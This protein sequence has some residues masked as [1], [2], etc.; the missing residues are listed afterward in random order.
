MARALFGSDVF[1]IFPYQL[2]GYGNPE[3]LESGAWWFYRKLGFVPRA[4]RAVALMKEEER[5]MA[6][7]PT[8]RTS[9]ADLRVLASENLYWFGGRARNDA[10]GLVELPNVGLRVTDAVAARFGSDRERAEAVLRR[11]AARLLGVQPDGWTPRG[12]PR[13]PALG[14]ARLDPPGRRDAG[15]RREARARRR[16]PGQGRAMRVGLRPPLRP[17]SEAPKGDRRA[18]GRARLSRRKASLQAGD[19]FANFATN[20]LRPARSK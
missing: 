1:T 7:D 4:P 15:R 5:R 14:A 20:F 6:A 10:I 9:L 16:R 12:T 8:H 11:E 18:R 17:A 13:V 19:R 2:G 3:A